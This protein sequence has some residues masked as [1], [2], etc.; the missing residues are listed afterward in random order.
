[1]NRTEK[2]SLG[3]KQIPSDALYGI[4]SVRARENFPGNTRF[5]LEWYKAVGITKLACYN[6]Y[7]KFRKAAGDKITGNPNLKKINEDTLN[8][9]ITAAKEVA[10]GDHFDQFI[11]QAVQG[12]AGTSI[13]MNINEII[14]NAALR[15]S[16]HKC[17]E[18]SYI[19]PTEDANIYQ[20]TND[21]IPT[22]LTVAVMQL[23]QQLEDKINILRQKVEELE[24]KNRDKLRPGYTEMQAAVPSS[25]G[26]LFSTY[27]E[28]LSRDWWRV[29]KCSER[30]KQVNLGGGA[31]G[32]GLSLP[33]YF[34]MEVV[35]ELRKLTGLPIAHSE[36]LSDATSNMDRWVEIHATL[37]AHAVN[38]EKMSSD[39]RLLSSDITGNKPVSIPDR[40]VGSSIMPGKVNPVI[41][42]FVISAAH[43]IYSN[44]VLI[45]S[46][47]GQGTLEL[48]AYIP[49]IGYAV[50]ESLNLL[51][52]CNETLLSNLFE[53]LLVN[54]SAGYEALI[55][56]PSVT[57]ALSPY[58]G[59]HKASKLAVL[60]K[61][62]KINIFEAN[63]TL[64]VIDGK[65]L[66]SILE[67]G[68][69]LKLGFSIEEL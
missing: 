38:L 22:A 29:S 68:N 17:G 52:S 37:K 11:I 1:M 69:L 57:T 4:H 14:T 59:Y 9:L 39:L 67:P 60:M 20:S 49:V 65:K 40:Q 42:E 23:L 43:R 63:E 15:N 16:G 41:P 33:R 53:G 61:E 10:S 32:T 24:K 25:F 27:N 44:D 19:D 54:E 26:L 30:I 5:P 3:E 31:I 64:Q 46:L 50:I 62:K 66:K 47:S 6:T 35:P 56:S 45:S 18:Y 12:G 34:I 55:F 2:D 8:S 21:I 48:N 36:N 58:I 28:A 51:I 7:G 13:N